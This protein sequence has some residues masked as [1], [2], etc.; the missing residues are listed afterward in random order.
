MNAHGYF[1][2]PSTDISD[3]PL[4]SWL[5]LD[6]WE[7]E[8]ILANLAGNHTNPY[9]EFSLSPAACAWMAGYYGESDLLKRYPS[10]TLAQA[11]NFMEKA[12]GC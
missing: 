1:E 3:D 4:T 11:Q 7:L 8:G 5:E 2:W 12:G 10:W 6:V 9:D